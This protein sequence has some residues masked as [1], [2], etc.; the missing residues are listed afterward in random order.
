MSPRKGMINALR[1]PQGSLV[2][3][4]HGFCFFAGIIYFGWI[5]LFMVVG[6]LWWLGRAI[7]RA[8]G[9]I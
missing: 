5:I 2:S 4:I 7:L 8:M 9:L 1:Q 6:S 3:M